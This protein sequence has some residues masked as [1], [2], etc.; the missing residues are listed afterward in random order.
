MTSKRDLN[1]KARRQKILEISDEMFSNQGY[2]KTSVSDIAKKAGLG[3]GTVYNYFDSKDTIF[4]A[5]YGRKFGVDQALDID[6][7]EVHQESPLKPV[8]DYLESLEKIMGK[9]PK[10]LFHQ[11]IRIGL[12]NKKLMKA[13]ISY[14]L[15]MIEDMEK[16]IIKIKNEGY[17]NE[18]VSAKV[19]SEMVYSVYGF[20][21]VQY[22]YSDEEDIHDVFNR[23]KD[24]VQILLASQL[25]LKG[26]DQ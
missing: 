26:C 9:I 3:V 13:F 2:E 7:I 12:K 24:K 11:L 4:T 5:V 19:L 22:F 16:I 6:S 21:F 17:L 10:W 18:Q 23:G 20:E 14:D 15:K 8:F 25:Q 1:K